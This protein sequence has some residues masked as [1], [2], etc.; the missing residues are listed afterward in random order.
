VYQ[1]NGGPGAGMLSPPRG[2]Y[3]EVWTP[4][5]HVC[6]VCFPLT[7]LLCQPLQAPP[8]RALASLTPTPNCTPLLHSSSKSPQVLCR[9]CKLLILDIWPKISSTHLQRTQAVNTD[10]PP[11]RVKV[12]TSASP[13]TL[14]LT[15]G[16]ASQ[17][18]SE[19]SHSSSLSFSFNS[20]LC[21]C[22]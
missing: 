18:P 16:T 2:P 17:R 19:S 7:Q 1:A 13:L 14:L 4:T 21:K 3:S 6:N 15:P 22:H 20:H 9:S 11:A 12:P 8:F 10:Q 5:H